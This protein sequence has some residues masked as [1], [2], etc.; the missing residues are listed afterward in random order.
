[1]FR[2][3][4]LK[5]AITGGF[6][7]ASPG[8]VDNR[9]GKDAGD[10]AALIP[11]FSSETRWVSQTR[12]SDLTAGSH[13]TWH[14]YSPGPVDNRLGKDAGDAAALAGGHVN[15]RYFQWPVDNKLA[16][17]PG[18]AVAPMHSVRAFLAPQTRDSDLTI[19][20]TD[21]VDIGYRHLRFFRPHGFPTD[22]FNWIVAQCLLKVSSI[23]HALSISKAN[24]NHALIASACPI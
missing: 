4:K 12:D 5:A 20:R 1:M 2:F 11:W 10:A 24:Q 18:D 22:L 3:K 6:H 21:R 13:I 17:N 14:F 23:K 7:L 8:P 15:Y 16:K 9:L 19:G